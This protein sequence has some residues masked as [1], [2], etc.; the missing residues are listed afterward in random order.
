[1]KSN[2][3]NISAFFVENEAGEQT[4]QII[5]SEKFVDKDGNPIPWTIKKI[6]GERERLIENGCVTERVDRRTGTV[7]QLRDDNLYIASLA[8]DAVVFPD[9]ANS[10]LQKNR[11][12]KGKVDLLRKMLS[13]GELLR[14]STAVTEF[15]GLGDDLNKDIDYEEKSQAEIDAEYVKN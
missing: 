6:S 11:G 15:S 9:L 4:K 1:M 5:V 14:L 2:T 10:E 12:A 7:T 8:A 3:Y 13:V